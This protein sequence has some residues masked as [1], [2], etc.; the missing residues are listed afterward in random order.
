MTNIILKKLVI[1]L[2]GKAREE[3]KKRLKKT[4]YNFTYVPKQ[5]TF[6]LNN[7]ITKPV[8]V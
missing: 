3:P 1:L 8:H 4:K 5:R 7:L 2:F 6:L